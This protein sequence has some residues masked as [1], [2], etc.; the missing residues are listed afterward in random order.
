M[1]KKTKCLEKSKQLLLW[2][3]RKLILI[4]TA[5]L[6]GFANSINEDDK[7]IFGKQNNIEQRDKW[8]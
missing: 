4:T 1:Y 6:L 8:K 3:K 2:I 7:S 5:F